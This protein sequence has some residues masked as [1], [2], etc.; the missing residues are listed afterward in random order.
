M[1]LKSLMA[2]TVSLV[3]KDGRC[4][5]DIK[6][7]VQRDKIC[8]DNLNIPVEEGDTYER[9]LPN[10]IVEHYTVLDAGYHEGIRGIKAHYQSVVRKKT[11]IEPQQQPTQIVY[12]LIGPNAR[13]NIQSVDTSTNLVEV[14]PSELFKKLRE[15]IKHSITDKT[16]S[17]QLSEK[18]DELQQAQGTK[19]FATKYQEFMSLA[20]DHITILAPF[21]PAL[22]QML[23]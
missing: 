20:A 12:N 19:S 3:K 17:A 18:V 13:V 14:E 21:I 2:D 4:F 5:E 23:S 16:V 9:K 1:L 8:I 6:A 11:K 7:S 22:S 15:L 10:G